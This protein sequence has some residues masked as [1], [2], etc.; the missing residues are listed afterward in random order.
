MPIT[1]TTNDAAAL[2]ITVVAAFAA[3]PLRLL[4]PDGW[5]MPKAACSPWP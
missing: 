2:T 5:T 1:S 4:G 3:E